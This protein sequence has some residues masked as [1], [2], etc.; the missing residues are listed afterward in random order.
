MKIYD[1]EQGSEE[2]HALRCGIVTA[3]EVS[4]VLAKGQGKG[5]R[6]YM[7]ELAGE[8]LTG[9]V[10][11]SFTNAHMERGKAMEDEARA[12]YTMETANDVTRVGFVAN[13]HMGAS[14]DGLIG[15]EGSIEIK[16]ALPHILVETHR[17]GRFP[18]EHGAQI[19]AILWVTERPWCDAWMYWPKINPYLERI[20]R[21]E[22][23]IAEIAAAV[24]AFNKE[25]AELVDEMRAGMAS[26]PVKTEVPIDETAP[27]F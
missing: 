4:K 26:P 24:P 7:N 18:P 6:K 10:A 19:Q 25:L 22:R 12:A 27:A 5:R 13:E 14:P 8:R 15:E 1:C 23:K 11:E 17:V 3:S 21:D 9:T 20:H 16:T 2:W